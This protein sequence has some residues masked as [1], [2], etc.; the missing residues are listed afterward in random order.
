MLVEGPLRLNCEALLRRA[1]PY[2]DF[3]FIIK[4]LTRASK[5]VVKSTTSDIIGKLNTK[6]GHW[7]GRPATSAVIDSIASAIDYCRVTNE[8][9]L[10]THIWDPHRG[11]VP[12]RDAG[13]DR[14]DPLGSE[15]HHGH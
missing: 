5:G 13:E 6:M 14:H 11:A 9:H 2:G 12:P 8:E 3:S 1:I 7:S 4:E 15:G 10:R